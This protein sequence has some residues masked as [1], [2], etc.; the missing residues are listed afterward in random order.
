M[1]AIE[2]LSAARE[3]IVDKKNWCTG[4]SRKYTDEGKQYCVSGA[5]AE[6][7]RTG[8]MGYHSGADEAWTLLIASCNRLFGDDPEIEAADPLCPGTAVIL[9]NDKLGHDAII[10]A[11]DV[12]I[13]DYPEH[14]VKEPDTTTKVESIA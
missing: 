11:L 1:S 9:V 2:F 7:Y 5:I 3:L 4:R 10:L 13:G 12:A 14:A 8:S 6:V